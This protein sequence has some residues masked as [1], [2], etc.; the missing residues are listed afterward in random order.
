MA[1]WNRLQKLRDHLAGLQVTKHRKFDMECFIEFLDP[2]GD[3]IDSSAV[4]P[5]KI[6]VV[7]KNGPTCGSAVCMG[8]D[9]VIIFS[10]ANAVISYDT[11]LGYNVDGVIFSDAAAKLLGLNES[12]ANYMFGG[13]WTV[14]EL[15]QIR[16]RQAVKY[17]DKA[18]F[19]KD[20]YVHLTGQSRKRNYFEEA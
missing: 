5:T 10:P 1:N 8:G 6:G 9:A 20:V 13:D 15:D 4:E 7:R 3:T 18:I 2:D 14:T 12:E 17:L 11:W 16:R 19:N